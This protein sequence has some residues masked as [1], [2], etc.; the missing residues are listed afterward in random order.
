MKKIFSVFIIFF[1]IGAF[2]F[3]GGYAMLPL[4]EKE[5]VNR[6]WVKKEEIVDVFALSQAVPGVIAINS[7]V[8]I[9]YKIGGIPYAVAAMLGMVAPSVIIILALAPILIMFKDNLWIKKAFTGVRAAVTVLIGLSAFK[10]SRGILK[11]GF[12]WIYAVLSLGLL[13]FFDVNIIYIIILGA[14]SGL[15]YYRKKV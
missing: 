10:M 14:I 6:K 11:N 4:I 7:S 2:T 12:S 3:G 8:F 15:V 13:L 5:V 1:R 9:G